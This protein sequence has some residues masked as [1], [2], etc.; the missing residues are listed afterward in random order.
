MS[1]ARMDRIRRAARSRFAEQDGQERGSLDPDAV[2]QE[3]LLRAADVGNQARVAIEQAER[4]G[5][6]EGNPYHG[7]PLPFEG[8]A[9][10][11]DWWMKRLVERERIT[12]L[13]PPALA[14]RKED[15]E[16]DDVLD[17][18]DAEARVREVVEDFD[19]RVIEARRQL[20]GGPPVITRVRDVDE[21]VERWR[22]RRA[23]AA[24]APVEPGPDVHQRRR[25]W[26]RR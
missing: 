4:A 23:A 20:L 6:F 9:L 25:W 7:K 18:L 17:A 19:R 3:R 14:L 24:P 10:D 2:R 22:A 26:R 15:A 8:A 21:E 13:G 1:D 12:G 11:P 16:L 5:F